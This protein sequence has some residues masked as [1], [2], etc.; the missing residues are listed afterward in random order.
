VSGQITT[1]AEL[2]ALPVGSVVRWA[3]NGC[4]WEKSPAREEW[5]APGC[6]GPYPS[7][8][9]ASFPTAVL[10][11]PN[12]AIASA[13]T[14]RRLMI[15]V[16]ADTKMSRGKYAAQAVHA[17]LTLLG[18]HP[19]TPVIVLGSPK[20]A[21]KDMQVQIR[22]AGRT[23]VEPGTLTAGAEWDWRDTTMEREA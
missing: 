17:A 23:E 12:T 15:R 13:T 18:A 1:A 7:A 22:D 9:V 3:H 6:G 5:F 2:D 16:S 21:I 11:R 14:E 8:H 4:V 20:S 10:Y 19:Q